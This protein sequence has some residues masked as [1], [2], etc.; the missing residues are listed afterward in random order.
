M[1]GPACPSVWGMSSGTDH[2]VRAR[3][4]QAERRAVTR[5][6]LLSATIDVLA[7]VGYARLT[8][9]DV[10][11]R[12]GVTR[13]A[14]AKIDAVDVNEILAHVGRSR[15]APTVPK[16]PGAVES[17]WPPAAPATFA[18]GRSGAKRAALWR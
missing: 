7:D 18:C 13:G 9:A 15:T 2:T 4:S 12:A 17:C 1:I 8:T 10:C 5:T 16:S 11:A 3:R 14:Q 6:A